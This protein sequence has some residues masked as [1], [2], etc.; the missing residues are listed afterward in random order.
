M[1]SVNFKKNEKVYNSAQSE[2][3][4]MLQEQ[5]HEP[6]PGNLLNTS[7]PPS[8]SATITNTS[9]THAHVNDELLSHY[10]TLACML[11]MLN[12]DG[13]LFMQD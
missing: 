10:Y 4:K 1:F 5:G 3:F 7:N 11:K 6:E 13:N 2:V 8:T 12:G 9:H